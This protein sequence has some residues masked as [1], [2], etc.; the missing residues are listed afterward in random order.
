[1]ERYVEFEK[2]N[3]LLFNI[4]FDKFFMKIEWDN[5]SEWFLLNLI[6]FRYYP[7]IGLHLLNFNF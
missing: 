2:Y 7:E 4:R 1:M 3:K 6:L 5:Y